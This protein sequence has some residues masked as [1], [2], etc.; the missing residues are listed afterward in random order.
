M[1]IKREEFDVLTPPQKGGGAGG[2][3]GGKPKGVSSM[4]DEGSGGSGSGESGKKDDSNVEDYGEEAPS[5]VDDS[6]YTNTGVVKGQG[7]GGII[8][9]ETSRKIQEEL[10][11]P[12]ETGTA[13]DGE[14]LLDIA[15]RN[16]N[17]LS[18]GDP[19]TKRSGRGQ[20]LMRR[21]IAEL[22]K[23]KVNWKAQLKSFIGKAMSNAEMYIGSRRHIHSGE[24]LT[25]E[26]NK[27]DAIEKAVIAVDTSGSMG[28]T[29]LTI[30]LTEIHSIIT[31]KKIKKTDIVYFDDG[32]QNVDTVSNPPKFNFNKATGGGGTDFEAPIAYMDKEFKQGKLDIAIFCTDGYANLRLGIPKCVKSFIWVILDNPEFKA[33]WG[34]MVIHISKNDIKK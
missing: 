6:S 8:D 13:S 12:V 32:I 26:K 19:S 34:Q 17:L 30:I 2:S 4:P 10:G 9:E 20:G 7:L 24:Y 23:P 33:P 16:S 22:T 29:E 1:N 15:N 31:T 14:K 3:G 21:M 11:V 25:G 27:Y 28:Q 5:K 18:S